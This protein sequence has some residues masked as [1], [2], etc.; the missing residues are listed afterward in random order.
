MALS[1]EQAQ[2]AAFS[3][4]M[5]I[6]Y[7]DGALFLVI[8]IMKKQDSKMA[9]PQARPIAYF[10]NSCINPFQYPCVMCALFL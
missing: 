9:G 4:F 5:K 3:Q 7:A 1:F 6:L 8:K 10:P 2:E